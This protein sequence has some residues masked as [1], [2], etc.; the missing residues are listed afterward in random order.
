MKNLMFFIVLLSLFGCKSEIKQVQILTD[1]EWR[2]IL[3]NTLPLAEGNIPY[4]F[5]EY[6][7]TGLKDIISNIYV[8]CTDLGYE[9][10]DSILSHISNGKNKPITNRLDTMFNVS[11]VYDTIGFNDNYVIY[12][13]PFYVNKEI[14]CISMS[15]KKK[16]ENITLQWIIFLKKQNGRFKIIEFYDIKKDKFYKPAEII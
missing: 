9:I 14:I 10:N 3:V 7:N 8:N 6:E 13:E 2:D 11:F 12:S 4:I 16:P 15:N 5:K 1:G